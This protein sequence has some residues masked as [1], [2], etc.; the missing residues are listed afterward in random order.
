[1]TDELERGDLLSESLRA[2]LPPS[3][4]GIRRRVLYFMR[5]VDC[6]ICRGH[7]ARLAEIVPRLEGLGAD[8]TI[9]APAAG[10]RFSASWIAQQPFPVLLVEG[11]HA[12]AGLGRAFFGRLQQSGTIVVDQDGRVLL[13]RRASLP[14]QSFEERELFA[15]LEGAATAAAA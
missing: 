2:Q 7:V 8:V 13:A 12:A 10:A 1:M 11:A 3:R 6:V 5:A 4:V 15:T 14:F 9:F